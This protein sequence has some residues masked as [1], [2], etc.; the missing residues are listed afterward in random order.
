[1]DDLGQGFGP[2]RRLDPGAYGVQVDPDSGQRVPV[3][4]AEQDRSRS[5]PTGDLRLDVFQRGTAGVQDGTRRPRV[6][7]RVKS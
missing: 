2:G 7:S 1:V 6:S 3:Q 4:A 5:G